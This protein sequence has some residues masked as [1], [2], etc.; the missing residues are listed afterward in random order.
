MAAPTI[1]QVVNQMKGYISK[2]IG[3]PIWQ[4]LFYDHIIRDERDYEFHIKY[5]RENPLKWYFNGENH[6]DIMLYE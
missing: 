2:Q 3:E 1:S 6:D 5:I 4:K